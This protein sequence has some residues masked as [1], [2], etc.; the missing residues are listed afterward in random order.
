MNS[1]FAAGHFFKNLFWRKPF[2]S[3]ITILTL[4][5]SDKLVFGSF[6]DS[7]NYKNIEKTAQIF[8]NQARTEYCIAKH[9]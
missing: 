2:K 4:L 1:R 9:I 3:K 8:C 6:F 7:Q 5:V